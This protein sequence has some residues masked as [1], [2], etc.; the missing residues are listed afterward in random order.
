MELEVLAGL[1]AE[2][3]T[4]TATGLEPL[5]FAKRLQAEAEASHDE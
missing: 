3:A 4:D 1:L 5:E 2:K